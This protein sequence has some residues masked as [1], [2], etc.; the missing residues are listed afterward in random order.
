MWAPPSHRR[1]RLE[2][3]A[4]VDPV[5]GVSRR[6]V[7]RRH[8]AALEEP[9]GGRRRLVRLVR[10]VRHGVAVAAQAVS[11]PVLGPAAE[12]AAVVVVGRVVGRGRRVEGAAA[13]V[14]RRMPVVV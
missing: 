14:G 3:A 2:P 1:H 7:L 4:A 11:S 6:R 9:V 8:S 5:G 13:A 12:A 10:P